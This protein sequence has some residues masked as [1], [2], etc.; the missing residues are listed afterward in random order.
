MIKEN[1]KYLNRL[2]IVLDMS[3][4]IVAMGIAYWGRFVLLDGNI[5]LTQEQIIKIVGWTIPVYGI[6]YSKLGLYRPKRRESLFKECV[7]I[8][9]A[10]V[11]G[12]I[13]LMVG[14]F[15][16]KIVDFSR[17]MLGIFFVANVMLMLLERLAIRVVL[18]QFR[19]QGFNL[20]HCLV[21]GA[22]EISDDFINRIEKNKHW[23][24]RIEGILDNWIGPEKEYRGYPVLG[25]IDK[26]VDVLLHKYF[27]LVVIALTSED[28]EELGYILAQCEKAGVKSNVIP[29]YYKYVPTQPY[30]DDLD[31]LPVIDTRRV[32]LD[33]WF[34]SG[35][36]RTFDILFAS[37]AISAYVAHYA[38][39][40]DYD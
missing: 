29:Y 11:L 40:G 19:R 38:I 22:N 17:G 18:R 39:V 32:P 12:I 33:N 2:Q 3:L 8:F 5:S 15:F 13:C 23:G 20:R 30:M 21:I 4:V 10:N 28:T 9:Q 6:L 7:E 25:G 34:K 27:D 14:L 36:K 16:F 37:A 24:Y 1:Q 35:L 31:G 26:L